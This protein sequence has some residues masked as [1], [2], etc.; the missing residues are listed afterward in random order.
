MNAQQFELD[1]AKQL[2]VEKLG[3]YY[4]DYG[5]P[6]IG[7]R[8][9]GL[10]LVTGQSLTA[11]QIANLLRVSRGSVSTN[12]R[13]LASNGLVER[14]SMVGERSDHYA[15]SESIWERAIQMRVDGFMS[16]RR[17][18]EQ[19]RTAVDDGKHNSSTAHRHLH[20]MLQWV[21]TMINSHEQAL[22]D[23]RERTAPGS[24]GPSS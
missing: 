12:V 14:A 23:W 6:R 16:L 15:V 5:I 7:G 17:I 22:L 2:F 11:E 24:A 1:E 10:M 18:V 4:E 20:E 8:I 21:D 13:L 3:V 19:G 9:L